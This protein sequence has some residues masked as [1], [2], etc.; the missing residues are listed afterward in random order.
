VNKKY[1][2]DITDSQWHHIKDFFPVSKTTGR[3]REVDFREIV[4]A[5]LYLVFTGC[6]WRF[7]PR[8][9]PPWQT[10]YGYFRAWQKD[11]TWYRIHETLRSDVR[12]KKGRHKHPT[13]GSLDSQS[14]KTTAVPSSRGFDAGKKINGR[15]RHILVDT[16][17]LIITMTVTVASMQD[18]DGAKKLLKSFGAHR[19]KLRKVWVDGAYRGVLVEWV[20]RKFSYCLEVVLRSDDIKGFVVL[21]KRWVVERTFAWLS[22]HRR[23]SKDYERFTRTSETMIQLAMI[24]LMLRRLK[25]L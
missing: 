8:E 24:R 19:K 17:G 23:L 4:N 1:P 20:K 22:N 6:Q 3:P 2:T 11:G 15:K 21:P 12:R 18:R 16:L 13:A 9:Y 7:I 14:V 25:P 10:V 5:I